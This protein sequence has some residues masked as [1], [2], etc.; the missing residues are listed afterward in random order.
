MELYIV[1]IYGAWASW[2]RLEQ[3]WVRRVRVGESRRVLV[4]KGRGERVGAQG[5]EVKVEGG[6][7]GGDEQHRCMGLNSHGVSKVSVKDAAG[8]KQVEHK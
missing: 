6:W 7:V 8:V 3:V 2:R 1:T 5:R 4:A